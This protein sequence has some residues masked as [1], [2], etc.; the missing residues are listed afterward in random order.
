MTANNLLAWYALTVRSNSEQIVA[1]ALDRK[2]I[3]NFL[4]SFRS[5]RRWSDRTKEIQRPLFPGY[6]F[7][8]FDC[9]ERL[10]VLTTPAVVDIV[11]FG[12]KYVPVSEAELH[13]IRRVLESKA[14]CEP[15]AYLQVGQR[16]V[17]ESGP[18]MGI[19]GLLVEIK[20]TRRLVVSISLLQ[21]SVDVELN[22]EWVTSAPCWEV[23]RGA[24]ARA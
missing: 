9:N 10:P 17:V 8:R 11:G 20:R 5:L 21:R 19:E 3:E 22:S 13:A 7:A 23:G 12:Q 16:V 24:R 1:T 2:G 14:K 15:V 18:L 4:P 6:V